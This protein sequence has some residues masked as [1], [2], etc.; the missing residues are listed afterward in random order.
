MSWRERHGLG[1]R[2]ASVLIAIRTPGALRAS[3]GEHDPAAGPRSARTDPRRAPEQDEAHAP[4]AMERTK[5]PHLQGLLVMRMRGLEPPPSYLDTDLNRARLPIPPHPRA[6]RDAK[7][8]H[9]DS[10][11]EVAGEGPH[12][13]RLRGWVRPFGRA[14]S[15]CFA[16]LRAQLVRAAIVQGTRTPASHAGNPGSNPGSGTSFRPANAGRFAF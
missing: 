9:R 1:V 16:S 3:V 12:A 6:G 10:I 8:S 14:R 11:P 2:G 4:Q 15:G 5:K 13:L 7:I